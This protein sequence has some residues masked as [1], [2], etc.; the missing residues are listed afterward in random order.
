MNEFKE[1]LQ[2]P[3]DHLLET[4]ELKIARDSKIGKEA[5]SYKELYDNPEYREYFKYLMAT[6]MFY[7]NKRFLCS[8]YDI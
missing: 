5:S 7:Q 4:S 3:K 6:I 8:K 1:G 2:V